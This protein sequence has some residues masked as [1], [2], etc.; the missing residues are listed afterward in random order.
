METRV[1]TWN[2]CKNCRESSFYELVAWINGQ[3]RNHFANRAYIDFQNIEYKV[4]EIEKRFY[5]TDCDC[6]KCHEICECGDC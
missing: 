6:A 4:K 2:A 5:E 3:T 1:H